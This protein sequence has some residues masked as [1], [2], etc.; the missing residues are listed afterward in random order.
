M[1]QINKKRIKDPATEVAATD[2]RA[3]DKRL[4]VWGWRVVLKG[5]E[6]GGGNCGGTG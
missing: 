5:F 3:T 2:K 6:N 1:G 4:R